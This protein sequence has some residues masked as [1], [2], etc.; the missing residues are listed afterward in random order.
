MN[1]PGSLYVDKLGGEETLQILKAQEV[2]I[3]ED[4]G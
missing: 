1:D 4:N 3:S 2:D